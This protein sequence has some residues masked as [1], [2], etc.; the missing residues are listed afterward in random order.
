MNIYIN[1]KN[2]YK[3]IGRN[4]YFEDDQEIISLN[5]SSN[6]ILKV[7][8]DSRYKIK[9][10]WT[11]DSIF[12]WW[13]GGIY[14]ITNK[15]L[16]NS[17]KIGENIYF[18][19]LTNLTINRIYKMK[20]Q[21]I[22]KCGINKYTSTSN[23]SEFI[24]YYWVDGFKMYIKS[25][26]YK[27]FESCFNYSEPGNNNYHNCNECN[28][29]NYY[30]YF[31]DNK[32]KKNCYSSCKSE[33]KLKKEKNNKICIN[34]EDC[35][36]YISSIKKLVSLMVWKIQNIFMIKIEKF[37]KKFINYCKWLDIRRK[38]NLYYWM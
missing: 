34:K 13:W 12:I 15:K 25:L 14:I 9:F 23:N 8:Y 22:S 38:H 36:T 3:L 20:A 21:T 5:F 24:F 29:N 37:S 35:F 18:K 16:N 33:I 17:G 1:N 19:K 6:S 31:I 28:S 11:I 2:Y 7:N 30:Y 10:K 32:N 4:Y 27:C 26:C